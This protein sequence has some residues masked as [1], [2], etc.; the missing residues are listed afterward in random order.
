MHTTTLSI[1]TL[2]TALLT[3]LGA[4]AQHRLRGRVA[5]ADGQPVAQAAVILQ[6]VD[7]TYINSAVTDSL[8]VFAIDFKFGLSWCR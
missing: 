6:T 2:A 5:D 4:H 3:S 8:V 7:S 1:L